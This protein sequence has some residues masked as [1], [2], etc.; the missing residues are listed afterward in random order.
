MSEDTLFSKI[1]RREIPADIV[2]E[3]ELCLAFRDIA[4]QAP[5]HIL[6]IPKK[7]IPALSE[8]QEADKALLGHLLLAVGEIAQQQKL[9]TGYRVV[10]NTGEDGGQT[11]FH[12]HMH[13]LGGRSLSWPP[14]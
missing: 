4:P 2:Y 12:L 3:D 13:L 7:P 9:D 8:A 10:I 11:V 5:T 1:I 6:V 14:G